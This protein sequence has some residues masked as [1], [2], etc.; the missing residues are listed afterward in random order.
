MKPADS[1][2]KLKAGFIWL[3]CLAGLFCLTGLAEADGPAGTVLT[4]KDCVNM[5]LEKNPVMLS[6]EKG[7]E[8]AEWQK[9]QALTGFL[10]KFSA[11]YSFSRLDEAPTMSLLGQT[12]TR[13]T[14]DNW[15]LDA[16][17]TQP[18]FTGFSLLSQYKLA[19]LGLDAAEIAKARTRMDLIL[20]VKEAYFG[21]LQA[22]KG[23]EVADQS[24]KQLE[25]HLDVAKNFF[26]VGMVPKI[27]VLQ[28]EVRLAQALQDRTEAE[29]R[30]KYARA[31]LN[32]LLRRE[33][34]APVVIE[35]ILLY[36][37]FDKALSE[38]TGLALERRPEIKA[39]QRQIDINQQN[40][41]LAQA[42]YYPTVALSYNQTQAGDTWA[43]DGSPYH[44][45]HSWNVVA[46]ASWD[47]WE[48]GRTR[49]EVQASRTEVSRA[50]YALTQVQDAVRL[51]V[52][53]SFLNLEAAAKN[54]FVAQKAVEQ[55]QE[56]YRMSVERYREQ[57]ATTTEVTDAETLLTTARS[58]R[59]RALYQ[60]NLAWA[61]LERA[62]GLDNGVR[63]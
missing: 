54:I 52:K 55:A 19:E 27:D 62:M 36:K 2:S 20:Q 8:K 5:A 31:A 24:V 56:N 47:F 59:Y 3:C 29:N 1:F 14:R 7:I 43:V 42:G 16:S 32:T 33:L 34:D 35:D 17:V 4:L 28:A 58:N 41:R 11:S 44:E 15:S 51:E 60:Y 10:P 39:A 63:P 22:E 48:W 6:A 50:E 49:D 13:G 9:K 57:V 37:P 45:A 40:V 30:L 23:L 46:V 38:C 53:E 18:I 25:A 61:A 12:I 26:D 21:V